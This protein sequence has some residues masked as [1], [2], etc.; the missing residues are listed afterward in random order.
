MVT[1]FVGAVALR[2][3]WTGEF[4]DF[5]QQRMRWPLLIAGVAAFVL[6]VADAIRWDAEQRSDAH[7]R[8]A[9]VAPSIGWLML[10]PLLVLVAVAPTALGAAAV[11]RTDAYAGTERSGFAPLPASDPV[12]LTFLEFIDR[13]VWDD[14]VSLRERRVRLTG[15]VVN[16]P[17]YPDGFVLTRFTVACCAADALPV[18]VAVDGAPAPLADDTWVDAVVVWREPASPYD[19]A[20]GDWIVEAEL[21]DIEVLDGAPDA[22]YES[23]Y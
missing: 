22:P 3:A 12:S 2:L 9:R 23:P 5:L 16:D 21:V 6:G 14:D 19:L 17:R 13:A 1:L 4:G 15:F 20:G 10:V 8:R 18:Q 11:D 7:R